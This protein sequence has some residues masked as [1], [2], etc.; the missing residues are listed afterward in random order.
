[1]EGGF[2]AK[3]GA[4]TFLVTN[5]HV[6]ARAKG[7]MNEDIL[8]GNQAQGGTAAVAVGHDVFT[9]A[10]KPGGT[11]FE[12]MIGVDQ[13]ASIGDEVVVLGNAEGAGVINTIQG[14]IVGLGPNLVEVDA[15]FQP[16]NSGS[17]IIH[18]KTGKVIGIA[19]YLTIRKY[20]S[21]TK[22]AVKERIVRRFGYRLDS[23]K[24]WQPVNWQGF[25]AQATRTV[26]RSRN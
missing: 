14:T 4:G 10:L 22:V 6:A 15:P 18:L 26:E 24:T 25:Y 23:V 17:P 1:M 2:V 11:P 9:M 3:F 12:I 21:A 8:D 19:T 13:N 16:G 7:A 20:D 5:A